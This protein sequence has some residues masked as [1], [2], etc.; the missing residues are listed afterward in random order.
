M[1]LR[2]SEF[3][4]WIIVVL[5]APWAAYRAYVALVGGPTGNGPVWLAWAAFAAAIWSGGALPWRLAWAVRAPVVA[6]RLWLGRRW[7]WTFAIAPEPMRHGPHAI[8]VSRALGPDQ[9]D[10]VG[11][12]SEALEAL[13]ILQPS[14]AAR[15]KRLGVHFAVAPLHSY[16]AYFPSA[17][18]VAIDPRVLG[19]SIEALASIIVHESNH[20]LLDSRR[21]MHPLLE[22]RTERLA[23]LDVRLFGL[24]LLRA[25]K[26]AEARRVLDLV[27]GSARADYGWRAR[28]AG[29]KAAIARQSEGLKQNDA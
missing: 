19:E 12:V 28:L 3:L 23:R 25:G 20:A 7:R 6:V 2:R 22:E 10:A 26:V 21:L 13:A 18:L 16:A 29:T 27:R 17:K 5:V 8:W 9:R 15:L 4:F 24:A 14:R 11:R 1:H